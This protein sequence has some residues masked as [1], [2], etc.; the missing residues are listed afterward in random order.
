L[1]VEAA[2]DGAA[3][4]VADLAVTVQLG[5]LVPL[6]ADELVTKP[7]GVGDVVQL[8]SPSATRT[9]SSRIS[10]SCR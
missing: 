1:E 8:A 2:R 10:N 9:R 5:K 6:S 7:A 3:D 4:V